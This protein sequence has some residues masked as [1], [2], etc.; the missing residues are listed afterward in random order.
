MKLTGQVI[1]K[2]LSCEF[3]Y[4]GNQNGKSER[5]RGEFSGL[6]AFAAAHLREIPER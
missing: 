5:E 1:K 4:M 3:Y 6:I 2:F